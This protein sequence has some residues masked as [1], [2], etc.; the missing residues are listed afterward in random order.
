MKMDHEIKYEAADDEPQLYSPLTIAMV[1]IGA[2]VM[3]GLWLI[4]ASTAIQWIIEWAA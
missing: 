4:G 2:M 1:W 3:F